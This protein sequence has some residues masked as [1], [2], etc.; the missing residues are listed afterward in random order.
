MNTT[1]VEKTYS[2]LSDLTDEKALIEL[3][4]TLAEMVDICRKNGEMER[5]ARIEVWMCAL[6]HVC[7]Q[8]KRA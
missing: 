7:G 3:D 6:E 5:A 8:A 4:D 1:T 2:P